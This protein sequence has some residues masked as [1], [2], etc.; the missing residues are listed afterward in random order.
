MSDDLEHSIEIT[1]TESTGG[2]W[3]VEHEGHIKWFKDWGAM[4]AYV[5]QWRTKKGLK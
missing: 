3:T 1:H 4:M 2:P 5:I